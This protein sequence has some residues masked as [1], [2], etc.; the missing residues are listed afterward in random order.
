MAFKAFW[1]GALAGGVSP[2]QIAAE[3]LTSL[4]AK[5]REVLIDYLE[6][7]KRPADPFGSV[8]YTNALLQ[9]LP[10]DVLKAILFG[11]PEYLQ[12]AP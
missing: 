9:G 4:E 3:V 2:T 7:L 12:R 6:I 1:G 8:L 5:Q 11:S 10:D